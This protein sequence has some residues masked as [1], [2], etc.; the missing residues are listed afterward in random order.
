MSYI[1]LEIRKYVCPNGDCGSYKNEGLLTY[2]ITYECGVPP[3][4][5]CPS[6]NELHQRYFSLKTHIALVHKKLLADRG[7]YN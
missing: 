4:Y 5:R 6:C 2:H 7:R 3:K 1:I